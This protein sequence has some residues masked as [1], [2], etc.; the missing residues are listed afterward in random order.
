MIWITALQDK[1][2]LQCHFSAAPVLFNGW[3]LLASLGVLL[4]Y[5]HL[6]FGK[7]L[8]FAPTFS[9]RGTALCRSGFN[10]NLAH[11]PAHTY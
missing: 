4:A 2:V 6:V 8:C 3:I 1:G 9:K 5:H 11:A 7:P 10:I